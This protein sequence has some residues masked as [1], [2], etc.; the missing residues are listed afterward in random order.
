MIQQVPN[1]STHRMSGDSIRLKFGHE[2]P[3]LIGGLVRQAAQK[4]TTMMPK[5]RPFAQHEWSTYK[6]LRLAALTESPDAFGSTFAKEVQRS[7]TE[8]ASRL[9]SGV[10]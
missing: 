2:R 5:I 9:A 1:K 4:H 3:P 8:W 6:D 7:D 10:N